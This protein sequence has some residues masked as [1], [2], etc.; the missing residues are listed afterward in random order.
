MKQRRRT[1]IVAVIVVSFLLVSLYV[2]LRPKQMTFGVLPYGDHTYAIIGVEKGWFK[3]AGINLNLQ[4]VQID[5]AIALLKT[6]SIDIASIPP[7]ILFSSFDNAPGL[8]T[9]VFGD[10]FQGYA[11][12]AQPDAGYKTY[13]ELVAGG[14]SHKDA[15][16]AAVKQIKGKV[17]AYPT[18]TAI[19]PFITLMLAK[20]EIS[21]SEFT[22]HVM[23]DPGTLNEMRKKIA[24]FQVGGVPSRIT[25]QK[26]GFIPILTSFDIAKSATPSEESEELSSILQNGWAVRKDFYQKEKPTVLRLASVS[27]RIMQFMKTNTDEALAI[28]MAYLS[29]VSGQSFTPA[30]GKVIYESLDPF[31]TFDEQRTWFHDTNSTSYFRYINGSIINSFIKQALYKKNPPKVDDVI[32]ADDVYYELEELKQSTIEAFAKIERDNLLHGDKG[33]E[34]KYERAKRFFEAFNFYDSNLLAKEILSGEGK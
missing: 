24:D 27:F 17:F 28:H 12:M 22:P 7:G 23:N 32:F 15:L 8:C 18:E 30:D 19:K 16:K 25:L 33:L 13:S 34:I 11:L 9:F 26:E 2:L 5:Q 1:A 4:L 6:K 21:E 20:G 29:Q 31:Y 3:E 10:L 14:L